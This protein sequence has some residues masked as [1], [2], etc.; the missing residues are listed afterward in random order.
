M[1]NS[2]ENVESL[3]FGDW[4]RR[5]SKCEKTVNFYSY[6]RSDEQ[7][8]R[9]VAEVM[10]GRLFEGEAGRRGALSVERM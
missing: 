4:K 10:Y 6:L 8:L 9:G 5:A 3:C 7:F 1:E 2:V